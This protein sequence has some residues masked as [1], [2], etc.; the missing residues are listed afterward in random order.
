MNW[1]Q[2]VRQIGRTKLSHFGRQ[3]IDQLVD[4]RPTIGQLVAHVPICRPIAKVRSIGLQ[5]NITDFK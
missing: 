1:S 3:N 2:L 5:I 4:Y